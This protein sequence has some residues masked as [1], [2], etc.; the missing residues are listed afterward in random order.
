MERSNKAGN[1]L[2]VKVTSMEG[3]ERGVKEAYAY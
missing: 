1:A 3:H 2:V